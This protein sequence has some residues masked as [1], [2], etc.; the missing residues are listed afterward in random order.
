M[1]NIFDL[2]DAVTGIS[3]SLR[4]NREGNAARRQESF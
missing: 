4:A 2:A 3:D 1:A